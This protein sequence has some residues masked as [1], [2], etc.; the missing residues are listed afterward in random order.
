ME[1]PEGQETLHPEVLDEACAI[2]TS[3][4]LLAF[5]RGGLG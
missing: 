5:G 3:A 2:V 1:R 4:R